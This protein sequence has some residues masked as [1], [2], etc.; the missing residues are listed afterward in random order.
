MKTKENDNKKVQG[1][2]QKDILFAAL[3]LFS[4]KGYNATTT[5]SIAQKANVSE[6]TLFKHFPSK[7]DLFNEAIDVTL[8]KFMQETPKLDLSNK[9][10]HQLIM[11]LYEKKIALLDKNPHLLSIMAHEYFLNSELRDTMK[12][13][14]E[15]NYLPII[16]SEFKLSPQNQEEYGDIF[17][18]TL[19]QIIIS[20][21][22]GY[23]VAKK[24]APPDKAF[25]DKKHI[26]LMLKILFNGING[27][28]Q[29]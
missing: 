25:D 24:T 1:S 16:K 11:E 7:Q 13:F 19:T 28:E 22:M 6:K 26:E 5:L 20:L 14:W 17:N 23:A 8:C 21:L 15:E 10:F 27:L 29:K 9:S 12:T 2:K 3:E 18:G 4:E